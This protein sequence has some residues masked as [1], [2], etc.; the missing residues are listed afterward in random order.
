M[1]CLSFHSLIT[2]NLTSFQYYYGI[3][4]KEYS[5]HPQESSHSIAYYIHCHDCVIDDCSQYDTILIEDCSHCSFQFSIIK[6]TVIIRNSQDITLSACTKRLF[7]EF[8]LSGI[9]IFSSCKG[10]LTYVYTCSNPIYVNTPLQNTIT[11]PYNVPQDHIQEKLEKVG[12]TGR[13]CWDLGVDL[14]GVHFPCARL[15]PSL[16][17][18]F[19]SHP[20][21]NCEQEESIA[22]Q[23]PLLP[24]EY[25]DVF[26]QVFNSM[27]R[28]F[29]VCSM[30]QTTFQG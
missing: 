7:I 30:K 15:P 24:K 23:L 6:S 14:K 22:L 12:L 4:N 2:H 17:T 16:F 9:F 27:K 13:N 20:V 5:I 11:A 25:E 10:I 8:V 21:L 18:P 29:I 19:V 28:S 26:V 3:S 1:T